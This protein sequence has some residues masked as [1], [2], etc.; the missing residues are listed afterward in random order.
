MEIV[1]NTLKGVFLFKKGRYQYVE[2]LIKLA[3]LMADNLTLTIGVVAS[4]VEV[5]PIKINPWSRIFNWI[6]EAIVG[7]LKK[8]FFE[9]KKDSEAKTADRMRWDILSFANSCRR[10]Q[11]HSKDEWWHC[12]SQIKEYEE[13]TQKKDIINGVIEED[14]EYLRE[15][16]HERNL[17]NDFLGGKKNELLDFK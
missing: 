12:I 17:K 15:L 5:A 1:N 13:Y 2:A 14:S 9:F 11:E 8:E 10:G 4:I 16:Y 7:D 3:E 6:A